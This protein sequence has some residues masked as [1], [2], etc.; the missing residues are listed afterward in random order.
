V[1]A[2]NGAKNWFDS[3]LAQAELAR[4]AEAAERAVAAAPAPAVLREAAGQTI[5]DDEAGW[6]RLTGDGQR[7]L[8]PLT[9]ERMQRLAHFQW[10]TNLLANFII[11]T[12]IAYML[13]NG[14]QIRIKDDEAQ[15]A[16]ER[17]WKDGINNWPLKLPK[18]VRELAMFGEQ[19]YPTFVDATSGFVRIG[20]LDPSLIETV[21][22]DPD[23]REQP[24]GIVT[25]RNRKG[26]A[27]RYRVIINEPETAFAETA[28]QI[29][30]TFTDGECFYFR[31][32]E[33]S[34]ATRGRSD[35]LA[36]MDW[37]DAYDQFLFGEVDRTLG[38][39]A[40]MWD[41]TLTGASPDEVTEKA[42]KITAPRPGAVRV[43]NENETWKA[44]APELNS[45]DTVNTA[46]LFRNH[47]L[48]GAVLPEHWFGGA[49]NVN[50]ATGD[51]MTEPTEKRM[52]MRRTYIGYMLESV[53]KYVVRKL[54]KI[55]DEGTLS[56]KQ[57]EIM[58]SLVVEWPE[59][60]AKDTTSYAAAIQQVT[61]ACAIAMQEGLLTRETSLRIISAMAIR[62]GVEI[63]V[64]QELAAAQAELAARGGDNLDGV[65]L[66]GDLTP[67]PPPVGAQKKKAPAAAA[68]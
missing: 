26:V 16:I 15:K 5:E 6:R 4:A 58:D 19:C 39:R 61:A 22:T 54:W 56:D 65:D 14:V 45:A 53:A 50:R 34:S 59:L 67:P 7:D 21:V 52:L 43:H 13:A 51:S 44:E 35:L 29:R 1:N 40:Y 64:E 68:A 33:L 25:R 20:Y 2:S 8:A 3:P 32:N 28:Q 17:H 24:I 27:K 30:T 66:N 63:D 18:K 37:L 23:N 60:T 62:L 48:G 36:Q 57:M 42:K 38:L 46:R 41:V 47:M 49:E 55:D 9:H 31:V 12:P 10:E 11:E